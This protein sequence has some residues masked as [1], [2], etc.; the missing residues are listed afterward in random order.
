MRYL[1]T[2]SAVGI[3]VSS[4]VGC[5]ASASGVVAHHKVHKVPSGRRALVPP[6]LL[7]KASRVAQCEEG[8]WHNAN[9]PTYFGALGWLWATWQAYRAPSFPISMADATPAQQTW[10]MAHFVG[11]AMGGWWPDQ[12]DCTGGY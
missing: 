12:G 4:F 5:A 9:G 1:T 11:A 6:E 2:L 8:G 3:V 10:A 7:A